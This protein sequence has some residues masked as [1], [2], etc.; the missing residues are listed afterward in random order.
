[1]K[2]AISRSG[3]QITRDD[4]MRLGELARADRRLMFERNQHWRSYRERLL[5]VALCQGAALHYLDGVTGVK[6]FDVWTFFA[7]SPD[8]PHPDAAL[9]RRRRIVDY[10]PSRF[11]RT[12]TAPPGF[13]GRRVDLFARDLGVPASA[14]P[15]TTLREWLRQPPTTTARRLAEK[16]VVMIEPEIGAVVWPEG[17]VSHQLST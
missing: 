7:R 12:L 1:V 8:R 4:L 10:G 9:F 14:D 17:S 11:G 15:A 5:C 13:T 2:P 6:D 16:A 3:E